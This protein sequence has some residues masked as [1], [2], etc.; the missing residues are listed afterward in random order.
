M[1][2]QPEYTS[3]ITHDHIH[4]IHSGK[5]DNIPQTSMTFFPSVTWSALENT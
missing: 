2:Q 4:T 5:I 1:T 3:T